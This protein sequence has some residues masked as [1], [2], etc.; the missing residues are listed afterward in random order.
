M[1]HQYQKKDDVARELIR[2]N[3]C[4][5]N[6]WRLWTYVSADRTLILCGS[7]ERF[8]VTGFL[9]FRGTAYFR[10]P[11]S[12]NEPL[13]KAGEPVDS[14]IADPFQQVISVL[15]RCE[16]FSVTCREVKFLAANESNQPLGEVLAENE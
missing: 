14:G 6:K 16:E 7:R 12:L 8:H 2:A 1:T 4:Q 5:N 10:L 3:D 15:S 9:I 13:F 11:L